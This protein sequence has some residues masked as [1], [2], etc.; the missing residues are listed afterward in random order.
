M[1][2][3]LV[4]V[5]FVLACAQCTKLPF[6]PV[7]SL[8][9]QA[10]TTGEDLD[11][12]GYLVTLDGDVGTGLRV[13]PNGSVTFEGLSPGQYT[14]ALEDVAENCTVA[15]DTTRLVVVEDDQPASIGFGVVCTRVGEG[16]GTLLVLVVTRGDT[17]DTDG[18]LVTLDVDGESQMVSPNGAVVFDAVS[19][20]EHSVALSGLAVS[21]RVE[22]PN[23]RAVMV[24]DGTIAQ[25]LFKVDCSGPP[26]PG[27]LEVS[28]STAGTVTDPNGYLVTVSGTNAKRV[29][30]NGTVEFKNLITGEHTVVLSDLADGC[31]VVGSDTQTV[32]L[33]EGSGAWAHFDVVCG[34]GEAGTILTQVVTSGNSVDV[35][36]YVVTLDGDP[37]L[38]QPV[39]PNGSVAFT[40]IAPGDHSAMLSEVAGNC[41]LVSPNPQTVGVAADDIARV[42]FEVTCSAPGSL[43]VQAT[44]SGSAIDADGYRVVVD[45][46]AAD[47][48][49]VGPNGSVTFSDLRA[50]EHSVTLEGVAPNCSVDGANPRTVLVPEAALAATAFEVSCVGTGTLV[51]QA[52]TTGTAP[53]ANGY[54]VTVDGDAEGALTVGPNAAVAFDALAAGEH[55]V[56]LT[57]VAPNCS[58]VDS[59]SQTVT[60]A[61]DATVSMTFELVCSG[62]ASLVVQATTTGS[63]VD[64]D[65]YV[66]TV[67]GD[68]EWSRALGP[69]ASV[70][71]EGLAGGEHL[72]ELSGVAE[73]CGIVDSNRRLVTVAEGAVMLVTF[74][75]L[76]AGPGSVWVEA[77]TTG[78]DPDVGGYLITIDGDS[79]SSRPIGANAS[80]LFEG[81]S[82]GEHVLALTGEAE[83]CSV[84]GSNPRTFAVAES[85]TSRVTFEI[86]CDPEGDPPST[87]TGVLKVYV[88]TSGCGQHS[89]EYLVT[90]D[91][92]MT[93]AVSSC[94][95]VKFSD[96]PVGDHS[97][98]L[99]DMGTNCSVSGSNPRSVT[100]EEGTQTRT[101]FDVV[102]H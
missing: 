59:N 55:V 14:V 101:T 91:G 65:G 39:S 77:T 34:E 73:N 5:L 10:V 8:G 20:G 12:D 3:F 80:V 13:G 75:V 31:R 41:S 57:G 36:G 95:W 17:V 27:T 40:S 82:A 16:V 22:D 78:S 47:G 33:P 83:N 86:G 88:T 64:V 32:T 6:E 45:G 76:C 19:I 71:F 61:E 37:G 42:I 92:T 7:Q 56:A 4:P 50:G 11:E 44:T 66:V 94:G 85:T 63:S 38:S 100:V 98:A 52:T 84:V 25:V 69:N 18:Y 97:V 54:V 48:Q 21:C 2:R 68:P 93:Q 26:E 28:V 99:S 81:L 46:E 74:N 15:G 72:I 30:A 67:D 35:D 24:H 62:T 60:V 1:R 79:S 29:S 90:L 43:L 51:V 87:A 53:D 23:P 49:A 102:C 9:V 89:S 70:V 96:L 58:V